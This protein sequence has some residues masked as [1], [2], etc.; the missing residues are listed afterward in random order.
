MAK[1]LKCRGPVADGQTICGKCNPAN[2]ATPARTQV[3]GT[4]LAILLIA[5]VGA[6]IIG[7]R[8]IS[9]DAEAAII[10][11]AIVDE[12][13]T[14]ADVLT[15]VVEVVN[16]GAE[17]TATTCTVIAEDGTGRLTDGLTETGTIG[18]DQAERIQI[19]L[20]TAANPGQLRVRC[21]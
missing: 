14:S 19:D 8:F 13:R 18:V 9:T 1:C 11:A 15:V 12:Y 3:H 20:A 10:D 5:V 6:A 7:S 17:A 2:L 16:N 21:R 4:M